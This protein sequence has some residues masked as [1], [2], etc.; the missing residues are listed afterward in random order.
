MS[1]AAAL[2]S[3]CFGALA[4]PQP[5]VCTTIVIA[6]EMKCGA[7]YSLI[8]ADD[9]VRCGSTICPLARAE[10]NGWGQFLINSKTQ[11][12]VGSGYLS[13]CGLSPWDG[14]AGLGASLC[15]PTG[16]FPT[17]APATPVPVTSAPAPAVCTAIVIAKGMKCGAGYSLISADD[18]V[19]CGSTICPLARAEYNGWGQFLINSRTQIFVGSGYLSSCGLSPWD[20]VAG[21][22]A[23]LCAP[24]VAPATLAPATTPRVTP[25]P[26]TR[27]PVTAVP[28]T[29]APATTAPATP[30]PST[31]APVTS[32]PVVCTAI[33]IAKGMKCG[34]GYSLISADD[35]VRCG[36]TI[37]P[38]ARAEYNGWGQFLINSRTQIFVGSG[39]LSSCGLSPWDGV[40]GL[41]ASLCAPTGDFPTIA[42]ATP[43]PVTSAPAPAVCTAI[44]IA[45]G[46]KCGA[47]Y[48]LIS[49]DDAVRCGS[50]ICPLARAEYN[51]WGRFLINSRTQIF[52]G[53]GYLSS[54]GLSPWD[55]VAGLGASLCAPTGDFPTIAP[56]TP[57]PVTSAPAPA[58]CTAI[59]IAKG[60]KCGAG[61]S[62]ISADDAVRCG[63]TICPLARAEYNGWGRFLINSRTQIFVGSGYLSSCGLS[64][65]DGVAG[66]G[67]SLCAPT[68]APATL[69]PA[70][71]PR[72]TPVPSTRAPATAVPATRAP[73][74]TAPATPA[75]STPAPVTSAPVV[76]AAIVIAKGMKCGPGYS[77]ISAD[78]AVRC[79]STICPLARAE[80][81]GWG[82]FLIN[83]RTQTFVGSGY[84]SSCGLSPWD[85][86][87]GLGASLCA[88]TGVF[89]TLAPATTPRVTRAPVTAVPATRAPATTAPAT[90]APS[91]RVP[92]TPAPAT[93]ASATPA[94]DT[95]APA[96]PAPVTSAPAM[97][98]PVVCTAIVITTGMECGA[99]YS[100]ISADD[101]VRCGS[102][103]C[104]LARAE[105]NGWGQFLINSRTQIFVGS[106]YLSSCG[107]SPWDGVVRL[108]ASLCA[109]TRAV[110]NT[111][112]ETPRSAPQPD[113]SLSTTTALVVGVVLGG[114]GL[115]TLLGVLIAMKVGPFAS[116]TP[117]VELG[118]AERSLLA[119]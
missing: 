100:L 40:A 55:G 21:L 75:P 118:Q 47:G 79:G 64:P 7:G 15:A 69:A 98:A 59:V 73:A 25:A 116:A 54:C 56:A 71:T 76:C 103:I 38:L 99:G 18:A 87:A 78:D 62:L 35:A 115:V 51:G 105:Y 85:G 22:G 42:P 82:Q 44:V 89:P 24:T 88:P 110:R 111:S 23:S 108:G 109:P 43:V 29:R 81:N 86:V 8:S 14:V 114:V 117:Q 27:A 97:S 60:M 83:S 113:L 61:Y 16:D 57:V 65:W 80:Y 34:P 104:P 17:I 46:M 12:F 101:A 30:A 9:A 45:K 10:Y 96:T 11:I 6:K 20:G 119:P 112:L 37:C 68:V 90:P 106:G 36:S 2:L 1:G 92:V 91:T 3:L 41:G 32:A 33:V 5:L 49:A 50:T 63:S 72:V 70:T 77:L 67:A 52:V 31:P 58:V 107:L 102:I 4:A 66:L 84:L 94:P 93:P 13:S 74:T 48:S 28:A 39:Y 53:S 95:R 26:S 19:R